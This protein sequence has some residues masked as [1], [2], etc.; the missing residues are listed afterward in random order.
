MSWTKEIFISTYKDNLNKIP[1][2]NRG[3]GF[4]AIFEA[5]EKKRLSYYSIIETG[6]V[7]PGFSIE[8][9]GQSTL[10]FDS[11]VNYYDGVVLSVD[12]ES[13]T[14]KH[15]HDNT[16]RKTIT[17]NDDSIRFLWNFRSDEAIHLFYLDSYDVDFE[18]PLAANLHH[19]NELVAISRFLEKGTLVAIDDCKFEKDD[20][21]IPAKINH[22]FVGKGLFVETFMNN[23]GAN[24][25]FDGYQ[26]LWEI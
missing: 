18:N 8:G 16:S 1:E 9:D 10:L 24:L 6:S 13:D 14:T 17:M 3:D 11:F 25:L 20:P 4:Q 2:R 22:K 15:A 5:L 21:R 23:I 7:R 12:L 19:I 26:Q